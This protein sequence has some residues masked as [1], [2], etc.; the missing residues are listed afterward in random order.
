MVNNHAAEIISIEN[1]KADE[2]ALRDILQTQ[3]LNE[4]GVNL[5]E[6]LSFLVVYQTAFSASAR[7][8]NAVDEMFQELL[9]AF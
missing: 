7:V 1:A 8:V 9:N 5:D 6:E 4:S 2:E 3:L